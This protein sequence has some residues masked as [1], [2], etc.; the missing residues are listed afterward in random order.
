MFKIDTKNPELNQLV[1][2][3]I[4]ELF[5]QILQQWTNWVVEGEYIGG[6]EHFILEEN[7][8]FMDFEIDDV[9]FE[10]W[11]T[12]KIRNYELYNAIRDYRHSEDCDFEYEHNY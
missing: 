8:Q 11:E 1:N 9:Q 4:N 10:Y 12:T 2:E 6:L 3:N 7:M 5:N